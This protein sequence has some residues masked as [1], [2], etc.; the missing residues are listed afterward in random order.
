MGFTLVE[1]IMSLGIISVISV[2]S[3]YTIFL[4][5]NL[6]DLTLATTE[7]EDS[8]RT[9]NHYMRRAVL[10]SKSITGGGNSLFLSSQD[11]CFSFVFDAGSQNIRFAEINESGCSPNL[12]PSNLFFPDS[13]RVEF[14][15]FTLFALATGGRQVNTN[16]SFVTIM[17]L[18]SYQTDFSGT[19]INLIDQ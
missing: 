10:G 9:F 8:T 7:L 13:T 14:F 19:Y 17:P 12:N 5:L 3:V 1:L 11:R 15:T 6:R 2:A 4:S 16:G 18:S